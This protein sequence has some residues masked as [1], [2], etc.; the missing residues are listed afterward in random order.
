MSKEKGFELK[1]KVTK[2]SNQTKK[3]DCIVLEFDDPI[4]REGI[5]AWAKAMNEAG[6]HKCATQVL[7]KLFLIEGWR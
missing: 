7:D 1:Y 5:R 2:L 6:Y 3:V 4:A